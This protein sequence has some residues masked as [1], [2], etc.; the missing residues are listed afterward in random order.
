MKKTVLP[1]FN[2]RE[3]KYLGSEGDFYANHL[4]SHLNEH[5]E[6]ILVPHRHSFYMSVL[7][8]RGTGTHE[9]EFNN[10]KI[11]PGK[12]FMM[13]PGQV[14]SWEFSEDIE[15][16]IFFH[17][18][19]F[20]DLNFTFEKLARYPFFSCLRN[21]PQ[22]I[23]KK[24]SLKTIELIYQEIVDEYDENRLLKFQK[25]I[26]LVNLLYINLSR[27]Y[28]PDTMNNYQHLSFLARLQE[29]ENLIDNNFKTTKYPRLYAMMMHV[30]VKH[31]NRI[32]KTCIDKTLSELIT[33]RIILEAKRMM[34]FSKNNI[35]EIIYELGYEDNAYFSRLFK[36]KTG[37][38]PSEFMNTINSKYR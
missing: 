22:I 28:I 26:S 16:Y 23:L 21:S 9:I 10:Y 31:L 1:I 38:T 20:F 15:G 30:S 6:N 7:I 13:M 19:D 12:V 24:A 29:L 35:S 36:K 11:G 34:A 33:D 37:K 14:H 4:S 3:F 5:K 17:S 32:C 25:I 2:I 27:Q 8:S 18:K